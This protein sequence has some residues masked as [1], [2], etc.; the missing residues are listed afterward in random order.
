MK[1]EFKFFVE[2]SQERNQEICDKYIKQSLENEHEVDEKTLGEL[3]CSELMLLYNNTDW[4]MSKISGN[5]SVGETNKEIFRNEIIRKINNES[6]YIIYSEI[7]HLPYFL[8]NRFLQVYTNEN[9]AYE[10]I[11]H[12]NGL[13]EK[14]NCR[15][16]IEKY[17][18]DMC[19]FWA[20]PVTCGFDEFIVDGGKEIIKISEFYKLP[21]KKYG[22]INPRFTANLIQYIQMAYLKEPTPGLQISDAFNRLIPYFDSSVML[23]PANFENN[24]LYESNAMSKDTKITIL[25]IKR[26]DKNWFALF[27]DQFALN[28]FYKNSS[29]SS[30]VSETIKSAYKSF[31]AD[32]E[33]CEGIVI[34]PGR[35]QLELTRKDMQQFFAEDKMEN[36]SLENIALLQRQILSMPKEKEDSDECKLL[37]R[38]L[39]DALINLPQIWVAYDEDYSNKFPYISMAGRLEVF[40][41]EENAIKAQRH[42]S[43]IEEGRF[44]VR[45]IESNIKNF[46]EN[47]LYLGGIAFNLDNGTALVDF[48]IDDYLS[49]REPFILDRSNRAIRC[50][51][52]RYLQGIHRYNNCKSIEKKAEYEKIWLPINKVLISNG[53]T[54][55]ANGIVYVLAEGPYVENVTF[56]TSKAYETRKKLLIENGQHDEQQLIA[57]GD[58][59]HG[60]IEVKNGIQTINFNGKG[61]YSA[62]FTD[63]KNADNARKKFLQY[64]YDENIIA[65]PFDEVLKQSLSCDGIV[66]DADC[67]DFFMDSAMMKS[68]AQ[69]MFENTKDNTQYDEG[70]RTQ[71]EYVNF[72]KNKK[73]WNIGIIAGVIAA[74]VLA[75]ALITSTPSPS[76]NIEEPKTQE[77]NGEDTG[78]E[79]ILDEEVINNKINNDNKKILEAVEE[80]YKDI[81]LTEKIDKI[82][83][84]Y[85]HD[86]EPKIPSIHMPGEENASVFI[87]HKESKANTPAWVG[88]DTK[89]EALVYFDFAKELGATRVICLVESESGMK[90]FTC[91]INDVING[92]MNNDWSFDEAERLFNE[93]E[94]NN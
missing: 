22:H 81:P 86:K 69:Q 4:F 75:I 25:S 62:V 70:N 57:P 15:F 91:D 80:K 53:L 55:L 11:D 8:N 19:D 40:T 26:N 59:R 65:M 35:E 38:K 50:Y 13:Y 84:T 24:N 49:Y 47:V 5:K 58:T 30:I 23:V 89:K 88:I 17:N 83:L 1:D 56:Y 37:K 31:L 94:Q 73:K 90:G 6:I 14:I 68:V 93:Q 78:E 48:K 45:K 12:L 27:T 43:E 77:L 34:N 67:L 46:F 60:I 61:R 52:L 10:V 79:S 42:F 33:D 54:A 72:E 21:E 16:Y 82:Y 51:L 66:V 7:T 74:I 2:I 41:T 85:D 29:Q 71:R 18:L 9:K 3:N 92:Y 63:K 32:T 64:G 20:L 87:T 28:H 44:S 36:E 76:P 39:W